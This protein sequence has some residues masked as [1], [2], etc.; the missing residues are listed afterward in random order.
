VTAP[1]PRAA[2]S[3][4]RAIAE[5]E[6]IVHDLGI[7]NGRLGVVAGHVE[8]IMA[9]A[10][11]EG[12]TEGIATREAARSLAYG[13]AENCADCRQPYTVWS[14][15]NDLW[16]A[17]MRPNGEQQDEPFLCA[18]CFLIRA[19]PVTEFADVVW[20]R[21]PS[22]RDRARSA[23]VAGADNAQDDAPERQP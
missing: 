23:A 19:Q 5:A 8:R 20:P 3:P 18:R 1:M 14:A 16:N 15:D 22:R 9:A 21:H 12:R 4:L 2:A 6:R 13:G 10:R 11:D 17:V 7:P